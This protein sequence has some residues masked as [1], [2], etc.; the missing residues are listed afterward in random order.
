MYRKKVSDEEKTYQTQQHLEKEL[1]ALARQYLV[2]DRDC[3]HSQ[4]SRGSSL[5]KGDKVIRIFQ[6]EHVNI[7]TDLMRAAAPGRTR[8]DEK[9]FDELSKLMDE[10][11]FYTIQVNEHKVYLREI[12]AEIKVFQ[13]SVHQLREQQTSDKQCEERVWH[14]IK[15]VEALEN[16]LETQM[17][18]FGK[19]CSKNK[20]LR[21]EI[22]HLLWQR[23]IFINQWQSLIDK[24]SDGKKIMLDLIEQ[25]TIAYNQRE[26][27]CNKLQILR[28]K[29]HHDLRHN[30]QEMRDI[31][32][33]YDHSMKLSE[34]FQ[35]KGQRRV[36]KDLEAREREKR[37]RLY[38]I[39]NEKVTKYHYMLNDIQN[40]CR[41]KNLK[42]I[43][44][45]FAKQEEFN[46]SKFKFV[47]ET[48]Q[49]MESVNDTLGFLYLDIDERFALHT[50]RDNQQ[51]IKLLELEASLEETRNAA[52]ESQ[53]KLNE[54]ETLF[55]GLLQ[56]IS[57]LF[58]LCKCVKDPLFRLLGNNTT[59]QFY[60]VGLY[61]QILETR[62]QEML[63]TAGYRDKNRKTGDKKRII[64]DKTVNNKIY[65][66][67]QIVKTTPCSLCVEHEMV[68]DVMDVLQHVLSRNEAKV[69]LS[70]R[71][72]LPGGTVRLHRISH[73]QLPKARQIM[74]KRYE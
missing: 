3:T 14:A 41:E 61:A 39:L 47:I 53:E 37:H 45:N 50:E 5:I 55:R 28:T 27:W 66:I 16:K 18:Q 36:M 17:K 49:E 48:I 58:Q 33:K 63:I 21:Y 2:L 7:L 25:A 38:E 6:K 67:D 52:S 12:E 34:F 62:V 60:N 42:N 46:L 59:V 1:N 8:E 29:A 64:D 24:L 68:S 9:L 71:M 43:A 35:I 56:G 22:D 74:Q 11:R 26:E 65:D 70:Q 30:I 23:R 57:S 15:T 44:R 54:T 20:E 69:K 31:R 19:L 10:N 72:Q 32:R 13:K 73:C 51:K 4:F 40:F